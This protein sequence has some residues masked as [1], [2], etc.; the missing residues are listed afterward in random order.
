MCV[1]VRI[2]FLVCISPRFHGDHCACTCVQGYGLAW[3]PFKQ[4][5]L[6]SGSD[7]AQICLWDVNVAQGKVLQAHHIYRS[8]AGV[9]EV[10][11]PADVQEQRCEVRKKLQTIQ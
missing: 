11:R 1:L 7:D 3:S 10:S 6:L 8:H 5:H 4:G 9:V 2:D